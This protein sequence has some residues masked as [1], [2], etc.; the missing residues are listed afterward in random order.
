MKD[1]AFEAV[2]RRTRDGVATTEFDIQ[3]LMA[4]WFRDEGLVSDSD[5]NVSAAENAGQSALPAHGGEPRARFAQDELV[6]LDLWGKARSAGRR[7]CRYH[8]GG[9]TGRRTPERDA[10]AFEAVAAARDAAIALVQRAAAAGRNCAAGR[11]IA[12]PRRCCG[13]PATANTSCIGPDTAWANRCTATA[14]T[15]TTTR[16]T[17]IGGCSLGT[18]FT[19]E[20]GVYFDDFGVRSEINMIVGPRDARSPG[21]CRPE[22]LSSRLAE[23]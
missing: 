15:W 6:L 12:R 10:R 22:I 20:P 18:G 17:T 14:S 8:V 16:P 5:P 3:Q 13:A 2:A 11:S 4:G 23:D 19:I 9:F 7:V 21:P 1:R